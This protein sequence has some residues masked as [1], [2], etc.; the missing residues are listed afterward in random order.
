MKEQLLFTCC[1]FAAVAA[2][3]ETDPSVSG[4]TLAQKTAGS[5]LATVT[6]TL[7]DGPAI[8]TAS[9]ATNGVALPDN[10]ATSLVGDINCIVTNTACSFTWNCEKDWPEQKITT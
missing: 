2:F 7:T 9:F 10:V 6:Y 3:A 1:L 5:R 4:V 8:V